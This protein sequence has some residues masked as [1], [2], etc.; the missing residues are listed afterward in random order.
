M[1]AP[2]DQHPAQSPQ[3]LS[4][5]DESQSM[6]DELVAATAKAAPPV[7]VVGAN[8]IFDLTLSE[9]V[10]VATLIY[11]ALQAFVLIRNEFFRRKAAN[12]TDR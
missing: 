8:R 1:R 4:L 12:E 9:W 5:P 11:L 6:K 3:A 7:A 10:A 2:L